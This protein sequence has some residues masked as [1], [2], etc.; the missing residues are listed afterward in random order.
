MQIN[1]LF[2]STVSDLQN[3]EVAYQPTNFYILEEIVLK[4]KVCSTHKF[5]GIA[6]MIKGLSVSPSVRTQKRRMKLNGFI[7]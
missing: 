7:N 4:M 5:T 2:V 1:Y 6:M 3:R